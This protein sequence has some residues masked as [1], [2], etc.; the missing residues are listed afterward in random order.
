MS[1]AVLSGMLFKGSCEAFAFGFDKWQR[2]HRHLKIHERNAFWQK[3]LVLRSG[4]GTRFTGK[5]VQK[6]V[7]EYK[8]LSTISVGIT[9]FHTLAHFVILPSRK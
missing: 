7:E 5:D 4:F 1:L 3:L 8:I 6:W 2:A 9:G